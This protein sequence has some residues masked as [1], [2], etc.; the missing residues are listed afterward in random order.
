MPRYLPLVS[1][2]RSMSNLSNL[3]D[4]TELKF[5]MLDA[6]NLA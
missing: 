4:V 2:F 3:L 6:S 1:L 5:H